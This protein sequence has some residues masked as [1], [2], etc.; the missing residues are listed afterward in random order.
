MAR[1]RGDAYFATLKDKK[2]TS[3]LL[4]R[5]NEYYENLM[6][7]GRL[8]LLRRL[9][10]YYY[11]GYFRGAQLQQTG[12]QAEFTTLSANHFRNLLQHLLVMTTAQRP[13]FEPH[14]ANTDFKSQ[15]Q[16]IVG[17]NVLDYY[18]DNHEKAMD[19]ILKQATEKTLVF[20]ESET[21]VEWDANAGEPV[22]ADEKSPGG[23]LRQGDIQFSV[24]NP[25]DAIRDV[26]VPGAE[27]M[28]W[29]IYRGFKNRFDLAARFPEASERI[30][31]LTIDTTLMNNRWIGPWR[32]RD[33]DLVPWYRF[34]H[35]KSD[36]LPQGRMAVF[37]D[38]EGPLMDGPLPY[39]F[40]PGFRMAANEQEA[41]PFAYSVS[42]DLLALQEAIDILYS[43]IL[44]NQSNYGV[45]NILM[46]TGAN[47]S[48]QELANGLNL[49][50]YDPK[51]GK[52]ESLNLTNT[53]TEVFKFIQTLE[54]LMETLAGVNSV[55]RGNP[56]ASLKSGAAL[57]LVQSMAL[58]FNSGLQQS[59]ARQVS[60]LGTAVLKILGKFA[61]TPRMV[62]IAGKTNR[63]YMK[64]FKAEDLRGINRVSVDMGNPL[65]RTTAGKI[66]M[67]ESLLEAK[68]IESG[69]QYIQVL[70]TGK[71]EPLIEGKQAELMLIRSENEMLSDGK[72]V[73]AVV[74]DNH[75]LHIFE[76][77]SVLASPEARANPET[78]KNCVTHLQE[79]INMLQQLS[80]SNPNLLIALG[81]QPVQPPPSQM[82]EPTMPIPPASPPRVGT[83]PQSPGL[84]PGASAENPLTREAGK[85]NLPAMPK[86]PITG[87]RVPV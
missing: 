30:L 84:A 36:I 11:I 21:L 34:Y 54:Q 18:N 50:T 80:V 26:G 76:H 33:S 56:E 27:N 35:A 5:I 70:T 69:E 38:A 22:M 16:T 73:I 57:A 9:S 4:E 8:A 81:Q 47:I 15:A 43:T 58:Q 24:F 62:E 59:Y 28:T 1:E 39:D 79:H 78:V 41:T 77:K 13:A 31:N 44:T 48:A 49:I 29:R 60:A 40:F 67:A 46:P 53:P 86:N 25:I 19:L 17:R 32:W 66:Q 71:L 7:T 64:E 23:I 61:K 51:Q 3:A 14:A 87:Q 52:P 68:L 82:L 75:A 63:S 85:V 12:E 20:G 2:F 55:A 37:V 74:T 10:K 42:F 83:P 45:Q 6:S 72:P 65:S